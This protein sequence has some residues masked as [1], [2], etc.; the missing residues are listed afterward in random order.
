[1]PFFRAAA[2]CVALA[3]FLLF[4]LPA[5]WAANALGR[6]TESKL[7]V[8]V[9]A[10]LCRI[11]GIRVLERGAPSSR[12]P[13]II[14]SNHVSWTD[15]LVLGARRSMCFLAKREV[16]SWPAFGALA[17]AQGCVFVDGR[18]R[19]QIPEVNRQVADRLLANKA[20]VLF[21]EATTSDGTRVKKFH[22]S[23]L[24]AARDALDRDVAL[25]RVAVQ[26]VAIVYRSRRGLPLGRAGRSMAAWYGDMDFLPS[27]WAL[28]VNG[29]L[30]CEVVYAAPIDFARG[31]D[32]KAAARRAESAVRAL[33]NVSLTGRAQPVRTTV[34]DAVLIARKKA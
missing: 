20:V 30:E 11:L 32:R 2:L 9:C 17:R 23:H 22:S 19:M 3:G 25:G 12:R 26:P 27:V 6:R 14:V 28:L 24:G 33:V 7:P 34:G 29:P 1:M 13:T 8:W 31:D 16:A 4:A 10:A 5:Q 15:V 21:A 18:R